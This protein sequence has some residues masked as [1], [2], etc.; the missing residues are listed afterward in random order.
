[1]TLSALF[2]KYQITDS[3]VDGE[4]SPQMSASR[5]IDPTE[6][7][8]I[9]RYKSSKLN[10]RSTLDYRELLARDDINAVMIAV[11][12]HCPQKRTLVGIWER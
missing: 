11:P 10:S 8:R 6:V 7:K 3:L 1:M 5:H 4:I 9:S 2:A 12:D